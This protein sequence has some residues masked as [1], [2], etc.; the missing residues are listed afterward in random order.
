TVEQDP[1]GAVTAYQYDEAG[2]LVA[3]FPGEDE[4][5]TYEHDLGFVRVVRRGQSVLKYVR[6]VQGDISRSIVPVG[7]VTVYSYNKPG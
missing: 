1:L 6:N 4:P 7:H 3:L 5:T 2:R